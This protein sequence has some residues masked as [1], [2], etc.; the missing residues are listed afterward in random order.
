[1]TKT[2][3]TI[4]EK[5]Q[6]AIEKMSS[7]IFHNLTVKKDNPAIV[8]QNNEGSGYFIRL[9]NGELVIKDQQTKKG[10]VLKDGEIYLR[11]DEDVKLVSEKDLA[12]NNLFVRKPDFSVRVEAS[13]GFQA[14]EDG[15]IAFAPDYLSEDLCEVFYDGKLVYDGDAR[16]FMFVPQGTVVTGN[17]GV[18]Y[19]YPGVKN[20]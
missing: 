4:T 19:F 7:V 15:W 12:N 9:E 6:Q 8:L 2:E 11:G 1:M 5:V 14:P 3:Q 10:F 16:S 13:S 20:A 18:L 17:I